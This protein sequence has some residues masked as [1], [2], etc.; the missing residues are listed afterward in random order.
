MFSL[1]V[2]WIYPS[3]RPVFK[4]CWFF[5]TIGLQSL[6]AAALQL[7]I[8]WAEL[9]EAFSAAGDEAGVDVAFESVEARANSVCKGVCVCVRVC[10]FTCGC[11]I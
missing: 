5:R 6:S 10:F 7:R 8:L 11:S 1:V 2:A 9:L 4:T 3:A